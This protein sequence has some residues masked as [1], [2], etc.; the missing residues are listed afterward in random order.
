[1]IMSFFRS[2]KK[3]LTKLRSYKKDIAPVGFYFD[4]FSTDL[5]TI[6][7]LPIPMRIDKLSNG[8][9]TLFISLNREKLNKVCKR[10]KLNIN[11]NQF[12][13]IG[14]ENLIKYASIKQSELTF[15]DLNVEKIRNW[16]HRSTNLSGENPDLVKSFTYL[17]IQFLKT[18]FIIDKNNLNPIDN[19]EEYNNSL[20]E[21]CESIIKYF[22]KKIEKNT[23]LIKKE[24]KYDFEKLYLERKQ[25]Y[26]PLII[27]MPIRNFITDKSLE[28]GFVPY[29]I[30]DDILDSFY[31]NK[32][33][34]EE[35][36]NNTINLKVYE[37][38]KIINKT[39]TIDDLSTDSS[40]IGENSLDLEEI[41]L[42]LKLN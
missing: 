32:K 42:R 20:I 38:Y 9:P 13:E 35:G 41:L 16:W 27:K 28:M 37:N 12:Y 26:Y 3:I 5:F 1:M 18:Y 40:K 31:Y 11:F 29:L 17:T 2:N 30:Y 4:I 7:I 6:P 15:R 36:K 39:S 14:I 34:L 10:F 21:Y 23:I 22:Q 24:D 8:E 25:K 33:L 19:T